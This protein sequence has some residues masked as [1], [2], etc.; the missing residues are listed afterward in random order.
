MAEVDAVDLERKSVR[1]TELCRVEPGGAVCEN[2]ERV[3][4]GVITLRDKCA[5]DKG[6]LIDHKARAVTENGIFTRL[7]IDIVIG[8]LLHDRTSLCCGVC[9]VLSYNVF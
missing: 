8:F 6:F 7:V 5:A 1:L 2:V 3:T 9:M 4:C